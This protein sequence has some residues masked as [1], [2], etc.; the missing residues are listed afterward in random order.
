MGERE[1]RPSDNVLLDARVESQALLRT[2]EDSPQGWSQGASLRRLGLS[3]LETI[4]VRASWQGTRQLLLEAELQGVSAEGL[5]SVLGPSLPAY[6]R[7]AQAHRSLLGVVK[8]SIKPAALWR[9]AMLL[10]A[11]H[12][13]LRSTL[14]ATHIAG[15]ESQLQLPWEQSLGEVARV[16]SYYLGKGKKG[17][18]ESLL[19]MEVENATALRRLVESSVVQMP[20]L[21]PGLRLRSA[22]SGKRRWSV[23]SGTVSGVLGFDEKQVLWSNSEAFLLNYWR[24]GGSRWS[25][26][27]RLPN[28]AS[29]RNLNL[30]GLL[31]GGEFEGRAWSGLKQGLKVALPPPLEELNRHLS[32]LLALSRQTRWGLHSTARGYRIALSLK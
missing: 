21:F 14:V 13:P 29:G 12:Q 22:R 16:W 11:Y 6:R 7:S 20:T 24:Q 4:N 32:M 19:V 2:L 10:W 30:P 26:V 15:L 25:R 8:A 27:H 17:K 23:F 9:Q 3:Q 31:V 1:D 18:R 28:D 5:A